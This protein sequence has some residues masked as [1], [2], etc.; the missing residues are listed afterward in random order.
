MGCVTDNLIVPIHNSFTF[1]PGFYI[2]DSFP[3]SLDEHGILFD[4]KKLL[5]DINDSFKRYA[6]PECPITLLLFLI[7][8]ATLGLFSVFGDPPGLFI[9]IEFTALVILYTILNWF[10]KRMRRKSIK[11]A[12]NEFNHTL[13]HRSIWAEWNSDYNLIGES[14]FGDDANYEDQYTCDYNCTNCR[15]VLEPVLIIRKREDAS[16]FG[17]LTSGIP[18]LNGTF[19]NGLPPYDYTQP[20]LPQLP[21]Q[22]V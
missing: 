19:S 21:Y 18:S 22:V 17:T 10:L 13:I 12:I 16:R 6:L 2:I 4:V 11:M 15:R 20:T 5:Q 9:I 14:Y 3:P 1:Q 7:P 8:F